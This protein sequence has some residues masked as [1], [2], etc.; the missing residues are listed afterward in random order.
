M[1]YSRCRCCS[2]N[3]NYRRCRCCYYHCR[4][5]AAAVHCMQPTTH[6]EW[7][8]SAGQLHCHS[9][10]SVT[11]HVSGVMGAVALPKSNSSPPDQ[12]NPFVGSWAYTLP[13]R[14]TPAAMRATTTATVKDK[15]VMTTLLVRPGQRATSA[16]PDTYLSS[17]KSCQ[18]G[19]VGCLCGG[20][21]R[22]LQGHLQPEL[23]PVGASTEER[24]VYLGLR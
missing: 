11:T 13:S 20:Y 12:S 18:R 19:T 7:P 17:W 8:V 5:A 4:I 10:H 9:D 14:P 1:C 3:A 15:F 2:S 6:L 16:T 21:P 22:R 24:G 23:R